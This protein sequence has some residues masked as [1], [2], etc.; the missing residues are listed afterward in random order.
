MW[1]AALA[2]KAKDK[3]QVVSPPVSTRFADDLETQFT[4]AQ[5]DLG[6]ALEKA[7]DAAQSRQDTLHYGKRQL[8]RAINRD[9][10][11]RAQVLAQE[12][13]LF[14]A[15]VWLVTA[16][17]LFIKTAQGP[18]AGLNASGSL[19][20]WLPVA[21]AGA[22]AQLFLVV[23]LTALFVGAALWLYFKRRPDDRRPVKRQAD[24]LGADIAAEAQALDADVALLTQPIQQGQGLSKDLEALAKAQHKVFEVQIFF[25]ELSFL[26]PE[27]HRQSM[28]DLRR[29]LS[30]RTEPATL[31][32]FAVGLMLGLV[33]GWLAFAERGVPT[34][35][36][37]DIMRYPVFFMLLMAGVSVYAVAGLLSNLA[38]GFNQRDQDRAVEA[39]LDGV[40]S[41]YLANNGPRLDDI[42]R[43][44][45]DAMA[46]TRSRAAA[47]E[48]ASTKPAKP[49]STAA[50]PEAVLAGDL[51]PGSSDHWQPTSEKPVFVETA[52][53][54]SPR[55]FLRDGDSPPETSK[56]EGQPSRRRLLW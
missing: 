51:Q 41:A 52:F 9:V 2:A 37:P 16:V 34:G 55:P 26:V 5:T 17:L 23:G 28:V 38:S 27:N 53:A 50:A 3:T 44:V 21:D 47:M 30:G 24:R 10:S 15:I 39:A 31:I 13:R 43:R 46:V 45:D 36:T 4:G 32:V 29:Y 11:A 12:G 1:W 20:G 48:K 49:P 18:G 40:R 35:P 7:A 56:I 42:V 14:I 22:L 25:K 6:T 19:L 33:T 8:A 54:A